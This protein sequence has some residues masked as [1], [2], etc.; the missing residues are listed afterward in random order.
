MHGRN[1]ALVLLRSRHRQHAGIAR[2]DLLGL[3]THAAGDDHL[4]VLRHGFADRGERF[5]LGAV[6][7]AAGV[8]DDDVGA[9]M[10]A[11]ELIALRTQPGDD[12]LGIDQRLG[13]AQA[14]ETNARRSF[15]VIGSYMRLS[16]RNILSVCQ[17]QIAG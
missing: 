5:L 3:G 6:E 12:A 15:H 9:V 16:C 8:D 1:H 14:V 4:A 17:R 7:E 2:G 11:C 13:A 10:L